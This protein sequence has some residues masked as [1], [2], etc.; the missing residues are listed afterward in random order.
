LVI[1][2]GWG[3]VGREGSARVLSIVWV[4]SCTITA[5]GHCLGKAFYLAGAITC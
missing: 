2:E 3:G 4:S 5:P 1:R